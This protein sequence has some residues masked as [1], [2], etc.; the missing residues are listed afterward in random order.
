MICNS[1]VSFI[2]MMIPMLFLICAMCIIINECLPCNVIVSYVCTCPP[3]KCSERTPYFISR[4]IY[5]YLIYLYMCNSSLILWMLFFRES[6]ISIL[7]FS[8]LFTFTI[9]IVDLISYCIPFQILLI[10]A[11]KYK[12]Y[13]HF[14][15]NVHRVTYFILIRI[16]IILKLIFIKHVLIKINSYNTC[17]ATIDIDCLII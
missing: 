6:C 11:T 3:Y 7:D 16:S 8:P 12:I 5:I 10:L 15:V 1:F 13:A 14:Y 9:L 2:K 4:P 17:V